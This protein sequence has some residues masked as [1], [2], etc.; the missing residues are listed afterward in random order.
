MTVDACSQHKLMK[1]MNDFLPTTYF[2]SF[3]LN[4]CLHFISVLLIWQQRLK[5]ELRQIMKGGIC[6]LDAAPVTAMH[7]LKQGKG[8]LADT[9]AKYLSVF[10]LVSS[11]Q[12]NL[13]Q[14]DIIVLHKL[15]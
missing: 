15:S 1:G 7:W 14:F 13:L 4:V 3:L 10:S 2:R 11:E 9:Q 6:Q 12:L 5:N 8:K